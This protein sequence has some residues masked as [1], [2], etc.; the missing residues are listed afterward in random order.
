MRA[1]YWNGVDEV[2]VDEGEVDLF[3]CMFGEGFV[4]V[5]QSCDMW[6]EFFDHMGSMLMVFE[7]ILDVNA[8]Q[9]GGII[10]L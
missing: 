2:R 8:K 4:D 5:F 7:I 10:V 1:P 3:K 6:L 9:F